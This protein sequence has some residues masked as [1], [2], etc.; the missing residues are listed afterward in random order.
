MRLGREISEI[1]ELEY[2]MTVGQLCKVRNQIHQAVRINFQFE[3]ALFIS[4]AGY[5]NE[6]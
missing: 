5:C 4:R 2:A 3:F 1:H 6:D